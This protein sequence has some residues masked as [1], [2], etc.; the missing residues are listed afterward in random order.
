MYSDKKTPLFI[1]ILPVILLLLAVGMLTL[2]FLL[3][4]KDISTDSSAAI[5]EAVER[6][7]RQC[8]A[9]EGIY[10][11]NLQ[12][13]QDHYGLQVNTRDFYITY[14]AF[15]SNLPPQVTVT[16]KEAYED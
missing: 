13:L 14:S 6:S 11:P 12:Y 7:A 8:Y 15:A 4:R 2:F 9:V 5:R 3:P 16:P 10:P 1:R